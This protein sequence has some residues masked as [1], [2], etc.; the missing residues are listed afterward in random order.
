MPDGAPRGGVN[1]GCNFPFATFSLRIRFLTAFTASSSCKDFL[2]CMATR[3]RAI[4]WFGLKFRC[5]LRMWAR[6]ATTLSIHYAK[7]RASSAVFVLTAAIG[8]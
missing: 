7:P 4:A 1:T 2:A 6:T 3:A 5:D 8:W